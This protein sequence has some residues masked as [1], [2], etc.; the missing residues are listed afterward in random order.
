MTRSQ[1][2]Q[3]DAVEGGDTVV[4]A[5]PASIARMV[6]S[7]SRA[8]PHLLRAVYY[9]EY[10]ATE[11]DVGDRT[12]GPLDGP[13]FSR[14]VTDLRLDAYA[15][16]Q[17]ERVYSHGRLHCVLRGFDEA[18][19][20]NLVLSPTH[21]VMLSFDADAFASLDTFVGRCIQMLDEE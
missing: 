6:R 13:A 12:L 7:M 1:T 15:Q 20:L 16:H 21:G 8:S 17:Q 5:V 19:E 3:A 9:D 18:V 14:L 2:V 11:L 4:A 10:G